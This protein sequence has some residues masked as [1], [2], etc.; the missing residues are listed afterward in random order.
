MGLQVDKLRAHQV[1]PARRLLQLLQDGVPCAVDESDTGVGKTYTGCAVANALAR[2]TLIV[3]PKIA[4]SQWRRA[5]AHF[6]DSFSIVGYEKLR[7]GSTPFGRWEF[8]RLAGSLPY[9]HKCVNCQLVVNA[10]RLQPCYCHPQGIHCVES[11]KTSWKYGR[12]IWAPEIKF[13][14][15]DEFHRCNGRSSLT[16]DMALS[17]YRQ[18]IQVLGLT[19]T[20]ATSPLDMKVTGLLLGL[21]TYSGDNGFY[22][23]SASHGC[24]KFPYLPGWRWV[25]G[26]DKQIEAMTRIRNEIIPARGVRVRTSEIP[27]FPTREVSA[28]LYDIGQDAATV[29]KLYSEMESALKDLEAKAS[30][31]K[32]PNNPL[33]VLLRASQ[34]IELLK[35]PVM[36][37]LAQDLLDTNYSVALFVNF[38]QTLAELK[39]VLKCDLIIDG[40][41]VGKERD[42]AIDTFQRNE[43]RKILI[44]SRAGGICI[45]LH[46]LQGNFPRA[47]LVMPTPSAVTMTQVFGR[48]HRDGGKSHCFYR[49]ILA[50]KTVEVSTYKGL[51]TKLINLDTLRDGDFMP[52]GFP[53]FK[54][55][56]PF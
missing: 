36:A 42:A 46:D 8:P 41:V 48:L 31:D 54:R 2:P 44:N 55:N 7:T 22:S 12:W 10:E 26:R 33:T 34:K 20:L 14:I 30:Q 50:D 40:S 3:V 6:G 21:H 47:G 35:V 23:W 39:R 15:F 37:E 5:A 27:G 25:V 56:L 24:G 53:S 11:K 1:E 29:D 32:D 13:I 4:E 19:A 45:S 52:A 17:C 28:E 16:A 43:S 18:R 9:V 51:S 38:S 49:I